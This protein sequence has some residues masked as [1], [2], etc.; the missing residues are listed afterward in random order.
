MWAELIC[1]SESSS[2]FEMPQWRRLLGMQR[3]NVGSWRCGLQFGRKLWAG[4]VNLRVMRMSM[5]L[6]ALGP[7]DRTRGVSVQ[8]QS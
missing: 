5:V 6:G 2:L 8:N 1:E 7:D 3:R 4:N